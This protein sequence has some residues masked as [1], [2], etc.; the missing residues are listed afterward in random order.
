MRAA[1]LVCAGVL[2]NTV[3]AS[4]TNP[5]TRSLRSRQDNGDNGGDDGGDDESNYFEEVCFP[6]WANDNS[7][8]LGAHNTPCEVFQVLALECQANGTFFHLWAY[9]THTWPC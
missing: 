6:D 7:D 8:S 5:L 3:A 2:L 9:S 4:V 1:V